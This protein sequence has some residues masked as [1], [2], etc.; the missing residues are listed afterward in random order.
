[1]RI[2]ELPPERRVEAAALAALA[3][4]VRPGPGVMEERLSRSDARVIAAIDDRDRIVGVATARRLSGDRAVSDETAVHPRWRG[5]G[6]AEAMFRELTRIL[7]ADGVRVLEGE[8]SSER[9]REL[10]F[11]QRFGFR[12]TGATFAFGVEGYTDGTALFRTEAPL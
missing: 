8:T 9:V 7:R 1:M 11:F 6:I 5:C 4:D 10:R 12:V 2:V 3:W